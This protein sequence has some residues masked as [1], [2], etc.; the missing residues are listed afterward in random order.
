[1]SLART[2]RLAKKTETK[3]IIKTFKT[4]SQEKL[5]GEFPPVSTQRWEEVIAVDLKG[6]DY[7][8]KL[9][10]KSLEGFSVRPYYR[11]EDLQNL[12]FMGAAPGQFPYVRG[13]KAKNDW[14]VCQTIV[15]DDPAAAN[16]LALDSLQRGAQMINFKVLDKAF[17]AEQLDTLLAGIDVEAVELSFSGCAAKKLVVLFVEMLDKKGADPEKVFASFAVSPINSASVKGG[18]CKD[19]KWV[20]KVANLVTIAK[21]YKRLRVVSV[22][23]VLFDNCGADVAQQLAYTLAIAHDYVVKAMEAGLTI[24]EIAPAIKFEMPIGV[25]YF[26]EIAKFRALRLLWATV[27][28]PYN[29]VRG[30]SSRAR[31]HA[32]TS[33]WNQTAYDPYVNMLRGTTESMSAAIAGVDSMEVL[34][35]D[36]AYACAS[37]F[38]SRIARNTQ[39]LLK[40]ESHIDQVVDPAGGSYYIETLT[41]LL[42]KK[43][44]ELFKEVEEKGGYCAALRAGF[45]Q[46]QVAAKAATRAKNIATRRDILLGTNQYPN[47]TEEATAE[48]LS[49]AEPHSGT[50]CSCK[51]DKEFAPM[52]PCRGAE[53]F[54]ALRM[55]TDKSEKSPLAFMLTCGQLSFAR[56]RAQF[57]CN[58]FACA[59]IKVQDNTYFN[60]V[61]EGA[62]AALAAGAAITVVCAADDD[63][64]T[65]AIEAQKVIGDKSI[66]VVAG[67]PECRAELEAAGITHFISARDNVL[68]TLKA[69]QSELL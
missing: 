67:N 57:A 46:E 1:M 65:A 45:I 35:F 3:N 11:A 30:C 27:T 22:G 42:S 20:A 12:E 60:S 32:V 16:L 43:A 41:D 55:K 13:T 2:E 44:W 25:N 38:S 10:Y 56:A 68:E 54:E 18:F 61:S 28:A 24:D 51:A 6:G 58:F 39:I 64:A 59:G 34:P 66:I 62:E 8:K 31:V 52:T 9:V 63:Y 4:M 17:A 50:S 29:P 49:A 23:G 26:M 40:E 15:V 69:Y 47:F 37:E 5:M 14:K 33:A 48:M 21:K 53:E 7:D 19:D 36:H